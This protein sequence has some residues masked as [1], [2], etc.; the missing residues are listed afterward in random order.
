MIRALFCLALAV[1]AVA[2]A[3]AV[4]LTGVWE[5]TVTCQVFNGTYGK[6]KS[7]D[8]VLLIAQAGG[9][10]S[11]NLD[12]E[13]TFNGAV[14]DSTAKPTEQGEAVMNA[15]STDAT[16]LGGGDD[17]I[18]RLKVKVNV[19]KGTGTLSGESI[20][21]IAGSVFTCKYKHKRTST[22]VPKFLACPA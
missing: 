12:S 9:T 21:A 15:C 7:A 13:L 18:A 11:A 20:F 19:D 14:I 16:P 5:G 10:F 6:S 1:V 3:H 17:E 8:S 22:T 4:D 2:P